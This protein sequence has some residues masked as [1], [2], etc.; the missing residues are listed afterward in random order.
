[1]FILCSCGKMVYFL[2]DE[3]Y[4]CGKKLETPPI[5]PQE[6]ENQMRLVFDA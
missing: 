4:G 1:M 2:D 3:C 5:A 6:S